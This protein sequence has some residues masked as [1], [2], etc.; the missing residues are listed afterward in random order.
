MVYGRVHFIF[1]SHNGHFF[2]HVSTACCWS[3]IGDGVNLLC[4]TTVSST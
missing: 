3:L 1:F 4:G 2:I